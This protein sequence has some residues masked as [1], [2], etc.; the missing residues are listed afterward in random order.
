M[1]RRN[2]RVEALEHREV[3]STTLVDETKPDVVTE[4]ESTTDDVAQ[5]LGDEA[6]PAD[7]PVAETTTET[8]ETPALP[9]V[10]FGDGNFEPLPI[11]TKYMI[12]SGLRSGEAHLF[13]FDANG[14]LV[15]TGKNFTPFPGDA[16]R[17]SAVRG[18]VG[19]ANGDGVADLAFVSGPNMTTVLRVVDGKTGSDLVSTRTIFGD[20]FFGGA[21]ITLSDM[22]SDGKD[23]I[24]VSPD[25]GGGPR[26]R[27]FSVTDGKLVTKAD[28][29]GIDD[30]SFH[31]G[32]RTATGD[33]NGDGQQELL[34]AAGIGGGPRVAVFDGSKLGSN[35]TLPK[36]I[37]D[38]FA[39]GDD[40]VTLR[41]GVYIS[42]GDLNADGYS[43]LIVGAGPGGGPQ[44]IALDGKAV[45]T[46]AKAANSTPLAN[47]FAFNPNLRA[48]VRL[49]VKDVNNDGVADIVT[50]TG[51]AAL[52]QVRTFSAGGV[53]NQFGDP[54]A[55]TSVDPFAYVRNAGR[56]A[57]GV[58]LG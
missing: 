6:E 28:F 25:A 53:L 33:M 7:E 26:I 23:E 37:E 12:V 34:V 36:L 18:A 40:A 11:G 3:P 8:A 52:T 45:L 1:I 30:T 14:Q 15:D 27:V 17:Y 29:F 20:R 47:F 55:M 41:N 32:V 9:P 39:L 24:I 56:V 2:L 54:E 22:D 58:F 5:T 35:G 57:S 4:E 38:F 44:I 13:G 48:G 46:D 42:T 51:E 21:N 10:V 50:G 16:R 43:D 31:G 19:D 49:T